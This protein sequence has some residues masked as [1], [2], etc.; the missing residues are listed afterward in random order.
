VGHLLRLCDHLNPS[1]WM[2]NILQQ[3]YTFGRIGA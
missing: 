3:L 1:R 2:C